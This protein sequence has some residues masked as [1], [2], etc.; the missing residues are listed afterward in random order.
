MRIDFD[1]EAGD[2]CLLPEELPICRGSVHG[3][4]KDQSDRARIDCRIGISGGG[5]SPLTS[6][7]TVYGRQDG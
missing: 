6:N 4:G 1:G 2:C 7:V 3:I 5:M